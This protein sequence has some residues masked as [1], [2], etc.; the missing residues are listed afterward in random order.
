MRLF[1][2]PDTRFLSSSF[3]FKTLDTRLLWS[4]FLQKKAPTVSLQNNRSIQQ[5]NFPE[6]PVYH[7]IK[8]TKKCAQE[9]LFVCASGIQ[10]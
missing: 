6:R 7:I 8:G 3:L 10:Q 5:L 2:T 9:K 4:S 1:K